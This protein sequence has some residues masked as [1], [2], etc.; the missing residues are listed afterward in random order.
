MPVRDYMCVCVHDKHPAYAW[1]A[2]GTQSMPAVL[3]L[4][5]QP[6]SSPGLPT[7]YVYVLTG[8]SVAFLLCLLLLVFLLL[9]RQHQRKHGRSQGQGGV[10]WAGSLG[11]WEDS[12]PP[13][14]HF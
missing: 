1:H 12:P 9:H 5:F 10:T 6:P 4:W 2:V 8:V 11:C 14:S 7:E 13:N 3:I